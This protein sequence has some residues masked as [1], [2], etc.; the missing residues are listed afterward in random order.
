M[1]HKFAREMT[2][3]EQ[4]GR[5]RVGRRGPSQP[6]PRKERRGGRAD[7]DNSSCRFPAMVQYSTLVEVSTDHTYIEVHPIR[8]A[9]ADNSQDLFVYVRP[10]RGPQGFARAR[11][12]TC[13]IHTSNWWWGSS[14][15]SLLSRRRLVSRRSN[16]LRPHRLQFTK[17]LRCA[18]V[19]GC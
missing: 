13:T 5:E 2:P 4:M 19:L 11:S 7:V 16:M 8:A 9:V 17:L 3:P 14:V 12:M 6:V 10:L 18:S 1:E 15:L